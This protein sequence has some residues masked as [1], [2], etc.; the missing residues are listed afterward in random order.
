M[1]LWEVA[2]ECK[3]TSSS[4]FVRNDGSESKKEISAKKSILTNTASRLLKRAE[5]IVA[6][7]S[8][9]KFPALDLLK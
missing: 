4:Q 6:A 2:Q 5:S 8:S 7:V 3:V 9:G 1:C